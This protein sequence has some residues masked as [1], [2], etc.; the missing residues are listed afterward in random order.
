MGGVLISSSLPI[1]VAVELNTTTMKQYLSFELAGEIFAFHILNVKEIRAW[2]PAR[3]IP[4]APTFVKGV[5]DLRGQL[6][7]IIDLAQRFGGNPVQPT[8]FSVVIVLQLQVAEKQRE[9]GI[10]A[11]AVSDVV[12]VTPENTWEIPDLGAVIETHFIDGVLTGDP[13]VMLL[14]A[15][16]LMDPTSFELFEK[17]A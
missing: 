15:N 17:I 7:P 5:I 3:E 4:N 16:K 6:V 11:D 9:I 2:Q 10:V 8:P 12:D 13:M 1:G 14:D